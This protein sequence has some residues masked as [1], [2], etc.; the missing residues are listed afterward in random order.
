MNRIFTTKGIYFLL[1]GIQI[2]CFFF[3]TYSLYN[4]ITDEIALSGITKGLLKN[5]INDKGK[6]GLVMVYLKTH[7]SYAGLDKK[8]S[9]PVFRYSSMEILNK[10]KGFCGEYARV[11]IKMLHIAGIRARRFYLFGK[12]W[13]H[14]ILECE[15][16]S[17]WHLVDM[18]SDP[19]TAMS[20]EDIEK[21]DSPRFELLK[22]ENPQNPWIDYQSIRCFHNTIF[23][24][25]FKQVGLPVFLVIYL[26]SPYLIRSTLWLILFFLFYFL[27]IRLSR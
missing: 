19:T 2:S 22:N 15:I 3:M 26:E 13:E 11:G 27:R 5:E 25:K 20:P 24:N 17:K 23:L 7:I 21:I 9:R 6:V 16:N 4:H 1:I 8:A 18:F 10:G 14:V 12:R